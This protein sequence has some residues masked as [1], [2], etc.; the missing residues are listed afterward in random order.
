MAQSKRSKHANELPNS[1][2]PPA[3]SSRPAAHV[4]LRRFAGLFAICAL[5]GFALIQVPVVDRA[6]ATFTRGLV[7]TSA[8][9]IN[10]VGGDVVAN[11][12]VLQSRRNGFAVKMANGCNGL[13]VLIVLWSSI[14]AFPASAK[15]KMKGLAA[16]VVV[17]QAIN[18]VRFISLF[19]L[20]QYAPAWFDFAHL[21][22][23]ESMIML[24]SLII[25]W[26]W[27]QSVMRSGAP[28]LPQSAT[29]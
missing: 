9:G 21:Y 26:I 7:T 20:G 18:L 3:A 5:A 14:L 12:D 23:W 22:F 17:I 27:A 11:Y 8:A 16:A 13:H 6:V 24:D 4:S 25:F 15:Q 1:E 29:T 10:A 2:A 19:Y 28:G